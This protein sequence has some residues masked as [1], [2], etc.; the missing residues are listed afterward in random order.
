MRITESQL[1][2]II[3]EEASRLAEGALAPGPIA[4]KEEFKQLQP[5]DRITVNGAPSVVVEYDPFGAA[6]R[7]T[8]EGRS[9][10]ATLD[11][12]LAWAW[13]PGERPEIEVAW[14]SAGAPPTNTRR[15]PRRRPSYS[16]YD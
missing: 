9:T 16:Y 4:S 12:R 5:G 2:Q 3:R 15:A 11:A 8:R 1:R 13:E 14:V 7:Y 6:L 10:H